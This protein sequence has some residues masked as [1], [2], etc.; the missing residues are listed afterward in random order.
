MRAMPCLCLA[1][2]VSFATACVAQGTAPSTPTMSKSK[3]AMIWVGDDPPAEHSLRKLPPDVLPNP[4][5][6]DDLVLAKRSWRGEYEADA[7]GLPLL[8]LDGKPIPVLYDKKGKR[9][10]SGV[11]IPKTHPI[12]IAQGTL[13][14]DGLTAKARLNHDIP[15]LRY[16][17]LSV[18]DVGTV[19]VAQ[20]AFI[21]AA[22]QAE[23]FNG[24]TL[25]VMAG[26][27][28]VQLTSDRPLL[29]KGKKSAWVKIDQTYIADKRTPIMG[30][31]SSLHAPYEWPGAKS[32]AEVGS[33]NA[34]PLPKQL[35]PTLSGGEPCKGK[36]CAPPTPAQ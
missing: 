23:A 35:L 27:H 16:I 4:P 25:T 32:V 34:P 19:I 7:I 17:Y 6:Q 22:E 14:V 8:G 28:Q 33:K 24:N 21:G 13:T 29:D 26:G 31:G 3:D 11:K 10:K 30:Y 1:F 20:G 5:K 15:D 9:I 12:V 2:A 18:P 36:S